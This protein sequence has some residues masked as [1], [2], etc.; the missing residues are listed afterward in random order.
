[1]FRSPIV[2]STV[3]QL[4]KYVK[5][6]NSS[7]QDGDSLPDLILVS[8]ATW[9]INKLSSL[10]IDIKNTRC[11]TVIRG[12]TIYI[13]STAKEILIRMET[14]CSWKVSNLVSLV[15]LCLCISVG[16]MAGAIVTSPFD[17][18]KVSSVELYLRSS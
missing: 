17:V 13:V 6:N 5:P 2:F 12:P 14:L 15:S 8:L 10:L 1:V 9:N 7:S 11:I 4:S 16:G 18:V 3:L